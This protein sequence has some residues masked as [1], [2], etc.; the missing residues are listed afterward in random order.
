VSVAGSA[1]ASEEELARFCESVGDG[2]HTLAQP[3]TILR[4]AIPACSAP[5]ISADVLRHY[6][7]VSRGEV[8]RACALFASLQGLV[9]G[10]LR[11]G[12]PGVPGV[13]ECGRRIESVG[14]DSGAYE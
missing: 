13:C 14:Q 3:L 2:L 4:S 8:E 10:R 1:V 11:D 6:L 12:A 9:E 7:E 5:G